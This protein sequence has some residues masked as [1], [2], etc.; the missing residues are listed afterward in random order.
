MIF[1]GFAFLMTFLKKY[2]FSA[3]G[4]NLLVAALVIQ[5]AFLARGCF[6]LD[7]GLI[8]Y[9]CCWEFVKYIRYW[10][11]LFEANA[12]RYMLPM[13]IAQNWMATIVNIVL[14]QQ[15]CVHIYVENYPIIG[16]TNPVLNVFFTFPPNFLF[17]L[18]RPP[19]IWRTCGC[20]SISINHVI[21][22]DVA[23]AVVLISMGALLGRTTPIQLLFMALIE[24]IV[25]AANEFFQLEIL[26][27]CVL[28][29]NNNLSATTKQHIFY[30]SSLTL[31]I[32]IPLFTIIYIIIMHIRNL[33][34]SINVHCSD[35]KLK[36]AISMAFHCHSIT[37]FFPILFLE[38]KNCDFLSIFYHY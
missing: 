36:I 21:E 8:R 9:F 7:N 24:I 38:T 13:V 31:I 14:V 10:L 6:R 22:A 32:E 17:F 16:Q 4:F 15:I 28:D 27:V 1:I 23:A 3:T 20:C 19:P 12:A 29:L 11:E 33:L 25:Y 5:W 18:L 34:R 30:E 35:F 26:S 2:G 37:T